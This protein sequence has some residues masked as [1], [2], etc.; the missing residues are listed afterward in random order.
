MTINFI[1]IQKYK[2]PAP[3]RLPFFVTNLFLSTKFDIEIHSF[4]MNLSVL[5]PLILQY[6]NQNK[7]YISSKEKRRCCLP[8][9]N[10]CCVLGCCQG[11]WLLR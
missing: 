5:V 3:E 7:T 4:P 10:C 11:V 2:H 1:N 6:I 9:Q 8:M